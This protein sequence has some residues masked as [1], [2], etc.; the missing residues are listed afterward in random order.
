MVSRP[1]RWVD[2]RLGA[3][4]FA[5]RALG[6]VF[7]D[8]WSFM[9]VEIAAYSFIILVLTG[10]F[11]AFFY[12]ASSAETVYQ[13]SYAPL[14]GLEVSAAYQSV[15]HLS[16][17]VRAGLVM[18]QTHHWTADV[19]IAAIVAHLCRIFFT[20]AFRRP[21]E[22]NW[23][24]GVTMLLLALFNGFSGYSLLD[25]LLSATGLRIMYSVVQSVPVI[26][27]WMAFLVFGGEFPSDQILGRLLVLHIFIVPAL[28]AGLIGAH[29]ALVWHQKHTQFPE[30]GL[31]TEDNVVGSRLWPTYATKS[32]GLF[33]LLFAAVAALGG[34]AQINPIWLYGPFHPYQV[35]SPAQP[36]WY[37]GWIEGALRLFPNWTIQ[38][39]GFLVPNAFFPA[40]LLPGVTFG[41]LYAWPFLEQWL[42]KDR[43]PHNLLDRP[44]D[45]P[46]RTA[47]GT[48]TLSFYIML[49]FSASNDLYARW[50]QLSIGAVTAFLQWVTV[51]VP[52]VVGYLT[53]KICRGLSVS[54]APRFSHMPA[55]A[56]RHRR[57]APFESER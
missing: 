2:D 30:P 34:L 1:A 20:G 35:T 43:A 16:F 57:P 4:S 33:F 19:F 47:V 9:L 48:T 11:L 15:L 22:L 5:E 38:G 13:G 12:T 27:T 51:I 6:K 46:V 39:F 18:R 52:L 36:D 24:I 26:G 7:P 31:T 25:D 32:L 29:L 53:Y 49:F 55:S 45:R 10:T 3:S 17:D 56:M 42:T 54:G 21:R 40:V 44:R 23:L 28:L 37:L 14:R 41:L 50:L 8:H